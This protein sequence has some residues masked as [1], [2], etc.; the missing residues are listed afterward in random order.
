[1]R[2]LF[3]SLWEAHQRPDKMVPDKIMEFGVWWDLEFPFW[4][5]L[6]CMSIHG[7]LVSFQRHT[8]GMAD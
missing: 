5:M 6:S 4:G 3:L 7:Q 8:P 1:M 2:R